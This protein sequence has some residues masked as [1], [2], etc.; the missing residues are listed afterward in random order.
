MGIQ[1]ASYEYAIEWRS[2]GHHAYAD[3]LSRLPLLEAPAQS[4]QP[5]E[6]VLMT[7]N[8]DDA[9]IISHQITTWTQRD[10]VFAKVLFGFFQGGWA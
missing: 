5:A 8:F 2:A 6:L 10:S 3:A 7:E 9:P 1:I 4:T